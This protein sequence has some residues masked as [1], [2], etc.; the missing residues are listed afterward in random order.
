MSSDWIAQL[1]RQQ[2]NAPDA[3]TAV[4]IL[5]AA[6]QEEALRVLVSEALLSR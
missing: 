4:R 6:E 1:I 5:D 3:D 2:L